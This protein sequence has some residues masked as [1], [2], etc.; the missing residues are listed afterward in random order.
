M[1]KTLTSLSRSNIFPEN[2]KDYTKRDL[3]FKMKL[4]FCGGAKSVTGANYLLESDPG[5]KILVDCGLRQ[6]GRYCEVD[7]FKPFPYEPSTIHA[8]FITHA[9]ID[10][11]GRLPLLYKNGFRGKMYSTPP[12]KDFAHELF[13][14]SE[15][16]LSFEA[17]DCGE[18]PMYRVGEVEGLMSLWETA[19]YHQVI[20]VNGFSAKG[21]PASGWEFDL[22]TAKLQKD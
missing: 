10:H 19:A 16:I 18:E 3:A 21:G 2:C 12:T 7:N 1:R 6:G 22:I 14:D 8:V 13:L 20:K 4:T 11:I 17:K 15:K 9:H 5:T